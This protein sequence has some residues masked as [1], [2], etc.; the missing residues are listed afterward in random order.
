MRI[1]CLSRFFK[2]LGLTA[3]L[4]ISA[5]LLMISMGKALASGQFSKT[6]DNIHIEGIPF[7]KS[8][9]LVADCMRRNGSYNLRTSIDVNELITN[10]NGHLRW[11][12]RGDFGESCEI[13][14]VDD[15]YLGT[16][17]RARNGQHVDDA[18]DLDEHI[19]NING[20]LT[21]Q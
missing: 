2:A 17:C 14:G 18:I 5:S 8:V 3:A 6:C 9:H 4:P 12:S 10:D 20:V 16:T 21:Y 15:S 11:Q 19:A 13:L 7:T 1:T